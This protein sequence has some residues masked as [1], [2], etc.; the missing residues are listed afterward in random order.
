MDYVVVFVFCISVIAVVVVAVVIAA[1]R[2][3]ATDG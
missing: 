1:V 3:N 2:K